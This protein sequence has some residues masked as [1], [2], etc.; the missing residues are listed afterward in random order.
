MDQATGD[1]AI[2][3]VPYGRQRSLDANIPLADHLNVGEDLPDITR[4]MSDSQEVEYMVKQRITDGQRSI[5]QL[6][7]EWYS[8]IVELVSLQGLPARHTAIR[9]ELE[10]LT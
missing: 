3:A 2:Q 7:P 9:E 5:F 4:D 8:R 10:N 1:R 6:S